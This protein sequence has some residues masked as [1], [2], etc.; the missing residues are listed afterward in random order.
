MPYVFLYGQNGSMEETPASYQ[1]LVHNFG[2]NSSPS[3]ANF[4][5]RQT[6]LDF[7]H[8]YN[9]TLLKIVHNNFYVNNCLFSVSSVEEAISAQKLLCELFRRRGFH[10]RKWL[11]NNEQILK[12]ILDSKRTTLINNYFFDEGSHKRVLVVN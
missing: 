9:P 6:A 10:L 4:R 12:T 1:M 11:S 3:C 2:A 7:A 8:L 5:L